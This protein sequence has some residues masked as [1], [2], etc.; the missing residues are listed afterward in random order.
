MADAPVE[1]G[2]SEFFVGYLPRMPA[3]LARH[4]RAAAVALLLFAPVAA[5]AIV[6]FHDSLPTSAFDYGHPVELEGWLQSRPVPLLEVER[7][8][9]TG[10]LPSRSRYPLVAP[11]KFGAAGLV[12]GRDGERVHLE[13]TLAY[14][15]GR[16]W[17]EV[18][19]GSIRSLPGSP[20]AADEPVS[21]G[22]F[23]LAG[24]I[25]DS[26]CFMGVMNPG[27]GKT[28][29]ACATR[30]ISG[31]IPPV[32]CVRGGRHASYLL[33][34]GPNDEAVNHAVLDRIAEPVEVEGE[35]VRF[36]DLLVLRADPARI[37]RLP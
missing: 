17:V 13:G 16:T 32:L 26:K 11:G 7:P 22:T 6:A 21:L 1:R 9:S 14:R 10:E 15:N 4:V 31:G 29:K 25:V 3:G 30:C 33:L 5:A 23:T 28:H 2:E 34:V 37:R 18:V 20:A 36:G 35:V 12:A 19:E 27:E 8:G 24:E